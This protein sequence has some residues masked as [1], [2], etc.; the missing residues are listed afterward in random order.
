M[1]RRTFLKLAGMGS[2]AFASACTLESE[3]NL[4]SLVRIQDD[5]V[6]G[7][8][9]WYASTCR[10]CPAGCGVLA[11]NREGRVIKLEG[12]PLHP[13]NKGKLCIRGQAAVQEV[14]HPD[15]LKKPLIRQDNTW[16]TMDYDEAVS[17]LAQK[18]SKAAAR[19]DNRV[20]MLTEIEGDARLNL[21]QRSLDS[22]D[23]RPPTVFEPFSHEN[24]RA[25]NHSVFG[26]NGISSYRMEDSDVLAG[27]GADF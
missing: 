11:K 27:F 10:Q 7:E 26:I 22:W 17:L 14:Y 2:L 9:T 23:S 4:Y 5:M 25:A 15:R 6:S 8:A 24:L 13:V 18:T 3:K 1:D 21:F 16:K 20:R 12:N 19:G